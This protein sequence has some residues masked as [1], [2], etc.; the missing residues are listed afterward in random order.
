LQ[1]QNDHL[2]VCHVHHFVRDEGE[3]ELFDYVDDRQLMMHD[4]VKD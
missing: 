1:L 4:E 2:H 3:Q